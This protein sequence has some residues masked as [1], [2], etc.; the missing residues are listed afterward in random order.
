MHEIFNDIE[1]V[2]PGLK[3]QGVILLDY[4]IIEKRDQVIHLQKL[5]KM[6]LKRIKKEKPKGWEAAHKS[7]TISLEAITNELAMRKMYGNDWDNREKKK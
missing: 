3:L 6:R 5:L 7:M 1:V 4:S 2:L